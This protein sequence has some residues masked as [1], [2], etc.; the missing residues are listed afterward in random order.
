MLM[1]GNSVSMMTGASDFYLAAELIGFTAGLG[2]SLLLLVL[3]LRAGRLPGTPR[4]N[5]MIALCAVLWNLGGLY[6]MLSLVSGAPPFCRWSRVAMG[7]QFT[8]AAVWPL[9]MLAI[10]RPLAVLRWQQIGRTI[11]MWTAS[12]SSAAITALLWFSI[13]NGKEIWLHH[14]KSFTSY[15]GSIVLSLGVVMLLRGRNTSRAVW[16]SSLTVL[17]GALGTSMIVLLG[18]HSTRMEPY[19]LSSQQS[20][21]LIILGSFFLFARFRFADV[22]IRYSYRI[23]LAS[24]TATMLMLLIESPQVRYIVNQA[25]IPEV[26]RFYGSTALA[27]AILMSVALLDRSVGRLVSRLIFQLPDYR[28]AV[29]DFSSKISRLHFESEILAAARHSMEE[30]LDVAT[31]ETIPADRIPAHEWPPELAYGDVVEF[32]TCHGHRR[33]LDIDDV[34]LLVPVRVRGKLHSVLAIS[35]GPVR[36]CLVTQE[37]RYLQLIADQITSR[38]GGLRQEREEVERQ[39]REAL[40]LQQVTEAELRALRAQINPHFLFNSL[41]TIADLI[42]TN[43]RR[44]ETMTLRLAKVFRHVLA[45]SAR[46]LTSIREE[47]EFLQAYLH[48]EEARFGDR[49]KVTI[50]VAPEI[51]LENIPS[52]ILQ[53]LVENALKH[54]LGPKPG[55]GNLWISARASGNQVLLCVEDDGVGPGPARPAGSRS[56]VGLMNVAER[57]TT[58]Y[59]ERARITLVPRSEGG[60]LATVLVPRLETAVV[61]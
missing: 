38:I 20:V 21:L 53:P 17:L 36:R 24:F 8:A 19:S 26:A 18:K 25:A 29:R 13:I 39:S 34:E 5:T 40:L 14:L 59:Q 22:A 45:H 44:A 42:V 61:A 16:V 41:N 60:S 7:V 54:G 6:C 51:A 32:D 31:A 56:G 1:S 11:L 27:T 46:P 57:L 2:I 4:A 55:P 15:N 47:F 35:P 28:G 37:I 33:W 30:T 48:I 52:L 9:P 50:H 3:T 23:L 12:I 58:L 49:L 10:W 43:P